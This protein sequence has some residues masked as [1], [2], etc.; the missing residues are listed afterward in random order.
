MQDFLHILQLVGQFTWRNIIFIDMIF[1]IIVVFFQRKDPKAVWAWLLLLYFIPILG[2]VFFLLFGLDA[3]KKKMFKLKEMQE[4][5]EESTQSQKVG[6]RKHKLFSKSSE[7]GHYSDL[8]MYN[9]ESSESIASDNNTVDVFIDGN[10]KFDAL[11]EDLKKAEH[12]IHMEYYIIRNDAL[13]ERIREVLLE[14]ANAGVEVRILYD[15][16]GCRKTP[17]KYFTEMA[18]HENVETAVFFPAF[19]RRLQLRINYRNHRKILVID[20]K[21]G[22]VGGFNVGE[23]YIDQSKK[24]GHWRDTH[25]RVEG[26][27]VTELGIRFALDWNYAASTDLFADDS[28]FVEE[29][30]DTKDGVLMQIISSGPDSSLQNIRNNYMRL[31]HKAK[32]SIY[33]QTPYFV[34]DEAVRSALLVALHSGVEVNVMI[35]GKPDH[36]FVYWAN[37]SYVGELI[38]AG[39]KCYTYGNGFLHAK[40]VIVDSEVFCYGSANMDIRSFALNFEVNAV[41]FDKDLA[42]QMTKIF[43]NDVAVSHLITKEEYNK[44][45]AWFRFREQFCRLLS[46][47]L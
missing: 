42:S 34:P 3:H 12:F 39:A 32:K 7:A 47:L 37:M 41:C 29:E 24:F 25:L 19:F 43:E 35:P 18:S 28:Y 16:M 17:K 30:T 20:N 10:A 31:M 21:V 26:S 22:Y 38:E 36:P 40:G 44:R 27:A 45:N 33:I 6:L 11:I 4:K 2:F 13:M 15:A 9:L 5:I 23:E 8:L 1:A 14:R 46:P